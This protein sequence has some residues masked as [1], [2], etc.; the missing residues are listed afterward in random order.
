[1]VCLKLFAGASLQSDQGPVSGPAAQRRRLALL[2]LLAASHPRALPRE[3][4]LACLWPERDSEHARNLLSQA[5]YA[6]R[7]AL[8]EEAILAAGDEVRFNPE[9]TPCDVV[10]FARALAAGQLARA[11]GLYSGPFLDGFFL[12]DAPEFE[13]WVEGERERYRRSCCMALE[14]LAESAAADGDFAAAAEWW[15]RRVGGEPY[16]ARVTLRLM[17]ALEAAGDRAGALQQARVHAALLEQEFAAEPDPE[18]QALAERLR[19][20]PAVA[21]SIAGEAPLGKPQN[22]PAGRAEP[23]TVR[24]NGLLREAAIAGETTARGDSPALLTSRPPAA[25]TPRGLLPWRR[26]ALPTAALL[27]VVAVLWVVWLLPQTSTRAGAATE[28]TAAS[29][30]TLVVLPF[31]NLSNDPEEEYFS[32]GLTEELIGVLSRVQ[33]LRVVSRTSAFAFKGKAQD[34]RQI[35]EA[36]NVGTVLEGSVRKE[37]SRVRVMA[38]LINAADGFHLWAETYEREGTD[39]FAIQSDLALRIANAL[40]AE[41][42]PTERARLARRATKNPEAHAL[43]LKGRYFWNQRTSSA[44]R[45]ASEYFQRAIEADPQ[46][47]AAYAGLATTYSLQGLSGDLTPQEAG[48]RMREAALNAVDLD[49][50]LAEAHAAL[51]AYLDVHE[52][53]SAAAEREYLRAIEL[54]PSYSW[55][56]HFYGILLAAAGRLEEAVAQK[57]KAVELDPLAPQ[58][59]NSLGH[60]LLAVGRDEEAHAAFRNAL[61]LDSTSSAAHAGLGA[62]Y[63]ATGDLENAVHAHRRAVEL[64]PTSPN[65][66]AGLARVLALASRKEEARGMLGELQAAAARTRIYDPGVATVLLAL[67]DVEGALEWLERSYQQ[68]HPQLRF[69]RVSDEPRLANDARYRDLLRRIGLPH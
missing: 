13:Q 7:K 11:V 18:V 12:S 24:A 50:G 58:P 23:E 3:K 28:A 1:M 39:I 38:Q 32:D 44:Y 46:Y 34:I 10:S 55:V 4:V 68:R 27:G 64:A 40:Q 48:E 49:D 60:T 21:A 31:V 35:A 26:I 45:R 15:R 30:K 5:L 2:A 53:D 9:V 66:R 56:R 6:L 8:G 67:D 33:D 62:H 43:Y 22:A 59:S 42:T 41:L 20:E 51:G 25:R 47:A 17:E 36:L 61:E 63:E 37:Q 29:P 19:R 54:D 69:L 57:R 65:A 14:G 52:W 16:N